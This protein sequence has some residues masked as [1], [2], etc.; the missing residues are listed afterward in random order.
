V[1]VTG[2][3]GG[4]DIAT[5]SGAIAL[6]HIGTSSCSARPDAR[7]LENLDQSGYSSLRQARGSS[8]AAFGVRF[9]RDEL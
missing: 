3:C 8:G 1:T 5:G 7:S 2:R 6:D 9:S 4:A